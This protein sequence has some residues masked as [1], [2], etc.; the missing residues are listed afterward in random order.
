[1]QIKDQRD[2]EFVKEP[3][4]F[5]HRPHE[6]VGN[7]L[8]FGERR[9]S[10]TESC[11]PTPEVFKDKPK[12]AQK[13]QGGPKN[14]QGKGKGKPNWHRPNPQGYSIPKLEP[15]TVDILFNMAIPFIKFRA[16]EHERMNRTFPHK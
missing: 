7:D 13:K 2:N 8:S 15:S 6:R 3:K 12:G 16:K 11:K 5:I 9:P 1:M 14:N 4:S 10:R